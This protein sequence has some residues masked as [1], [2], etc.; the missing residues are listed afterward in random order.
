MPPAQQQLKVTLD[1][2]QRAGKTVTVVDGFTGTDSD[3]E[4]LGKE[5]KT[6]CGTGGSAKDGQI[7][8]QGDYKDKIVK[9]LQ[10]WGY[11]AK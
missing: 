10:D 4:K 7:L 5:L 1:K 8:I 2:K 3:L 9:W 6:K 11:K